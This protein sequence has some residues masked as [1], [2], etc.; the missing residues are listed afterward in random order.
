M[1]SSGKQTESQH[2]A[3]NS[4]LIKQLTQQLEKATNEQVKSAIREK[5]K[6]VKS[7]KPITK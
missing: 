7:G 4:Q 5:I 6:V 3:E 1:K 2:Q